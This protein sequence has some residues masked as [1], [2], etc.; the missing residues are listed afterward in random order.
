MRTTGLKLGRIFGI[1]VSA[2]IGVLFIGALLTWSL[3][4]AILPQSEP[5]LSGGAYWSVAALGALLFLGSLLAHELSHSVIA[6]RNDIEVEGITLWLFGGVAQFKS[7]AT[8]PGAEFRIAAAGPAMSFLLCGGF[9]GGAF[10]LTQ[11]GAP[12]LYSIVLAWLGIINGFL[13]VFNLL[14]GAPLD[15]G[16]IL[17]SAI[18]KV[19]GDRLQAKVWAARAGKVVALLLVAAGLAEVFLLGSYGGLWTAFIG[20]FL[21]GAARMEE[22]HYV[23]ES[24]LGD[25]AVSEAMVRE[26]QAVRSWTSVSEAVDGPFRWTSQTAVPVL[27]WSANVVGI[28]TMNQ[29]KR[30]SADQWAST[31]VTQ[32]MVPAAF[33]PTA[34]IDEPLTQVMAR[35]EPQAENVALVF[36]NG[37]L[38]GMVTPAE[39]Q[40]AVTLGRLAAKG[41]PVRTSGTPPTQSPPPPPAAP[42]QNWEPPVMHR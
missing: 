25:L 42:V 2:D 16:R 27:D 17:A 35:L 31:Q 23:G 19:R 20:W 7:E 14:P 6:R 33:I 36:D 40:R 24:A 30:L 5:G 11:A 4:T 8:K 22:S 29:V 15:G 28:I 38:A 12:D 21:L 37:R 18:W 41:S 1:D 26:P 39:I 10:L 9:L 34:T 13:A 32:I 3:A